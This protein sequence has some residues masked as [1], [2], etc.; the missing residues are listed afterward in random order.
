MR[1]VS[2][3]AVTSYSYFSAPLQLM[4]PAPQLAGLLPARVPSSYA[5]EPPPPACQPF[6]FDRPALA[7]LSTAQRANLYEAAETLLDIAVEFMLGAFQED[8]L[9]AAEVVFHRAAGG[10]SAI[11]PLGPAA[12][13]AE[14]DA[15]WLDLLA[16]AK[17]ARPITP[18]EAESIV[19]QARAQYRD[20]QRAKGGAL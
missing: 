17:R 8:A 20:G 2:Q 16:R 14:N 9:R 5:A 18:A 13:N 7:E 10:K 3:S 6:V 19:Q 1:I 12:F 15:D 4:L 11:R